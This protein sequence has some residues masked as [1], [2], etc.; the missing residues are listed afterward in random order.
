MENAHKIISKHSH[1]NAEGVLEK[2]I[3]DDCKEMSESEF[4]F[5]WRTNGRNLC[6]VCN[7]NKIYKCEKCPNCDTKL[8]NF[9]LAVED[10]YNDFMPPCLNKK[11]QNMKCPFCDY[12]I[13]INIMNNKQNCDKIWDTGY[14]DLLCKVCKSK[15][16][17][18]FYQCRFCDFAICLQCS[19]KGIFGAR[20]LLTFLIPLRRL[21]LYADEPSIFKYIP[22]LLNYGLKFENLD[23]T[24]NESPTRLLQ[25]V[26]YSQKVFGCMSKQ[27]R[28]P[29]KFLR[30]PA[31][32]D[33][34]DPFPE[35]LE[36][37]K[38]IKKTKELK[39]YIKKDNE[40]FLE[41]LADA[42]SKMDYLETLE[43]SKDLPF[44][45]L[46]KTLPCCK[47]LTSLKINCIF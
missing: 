29:R 38:L 28:I 4:S 23:F 41:Q 33:I 47:S 20:N 15:K 17:D 26:A 13:S 44:P 5:R 22:V 2:Y 24:P 42:I 25:Q 11:C 10:Y 40:K 18:F 30:G 9:Y 32:S 27:V 35:I 1:T 21:R 12:N 16:K 3:C 7:P 8:E 39:L 34:A 31:S 45:Q 46:G 14:K 19:R 36:I 43:I 37:I 6:S